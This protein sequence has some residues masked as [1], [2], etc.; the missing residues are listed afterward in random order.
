MFPVAAALLV[1]S[2]PI[3]ASDAI[4]KT[5]TVRRDA[6]LALV[7][8]VV[9]ISLYSPLYGWKHRPFEALAAGVV[10]GHPRASACCMV[11]ATVT[12]T[13]PNTAS[14]AT[15]AIIAMD[16][17]FSSSRDEPTIFCSQI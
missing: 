15:M 5:A 9:V 10:S 1:C 3:E 2:I 4:T 13:T 7:V 11:S 14:A 8:I 12:N 6:T 17:V 16:V